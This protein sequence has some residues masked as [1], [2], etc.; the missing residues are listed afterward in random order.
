MPVWGVWVN[1]AVCF[2]TDR[3]SL[4]AR[5]LLKNPAANVHLE[6]GDD[7]VIIEGRVREITDKDEMAAVDAAYFKKYKMKLS[8]AA[9]GVPFFIAV[10]P[11][12]VFTWHER[13]FA[14]SPTRWRF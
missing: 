10:E 9:S 14:E 12:V 8:D 7:V 2:G 11:K 13:N 3:T 6:S 1:G 5:N 4:K